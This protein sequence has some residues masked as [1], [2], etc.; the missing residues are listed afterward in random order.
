MARV[1][2]FCVQPFWR[3]GPNKLAH[4]ELRQFD[5]EPAAL[6]AGEA[7]ARRVGGA[8]VYSVE[9]DPEFQQWEKPRLLASHGEVP[10]ITF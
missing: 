4:G 6:R 7:T 2:I 9:G 1:T 3:A 5:R 8:L 10:E